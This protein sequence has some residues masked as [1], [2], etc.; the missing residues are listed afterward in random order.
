MLLCCVFNLI[1]FLKVKRDCKLPSFRLRVLNILDMKRVKH[2]KQLLVCAAS[3]TPF[4][5]IKIHV[6]HTVTN[7]FLDQ[8]PTFSSPS[9]KFHRPPLLIR[10]F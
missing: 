5:S 4:N 1:F 7:V 3:F 6:H 8:V 9:F 2:D 10:T